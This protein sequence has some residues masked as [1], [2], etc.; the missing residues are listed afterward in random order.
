MLNV[1]S[2]NEQDGSG[3]KASLACIREVTG[4]NLGRISDYPN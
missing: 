3:G 4:R 1:K 2:L